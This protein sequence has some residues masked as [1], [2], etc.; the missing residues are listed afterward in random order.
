MSKLVTFFLVMLLGC[1]MLGAIMRGGGG[2]VAVALAD[3]VTATNTTLTVDSTTDFLST[4]YVIIQAEKILY[5]SRTAT[6]FMGCTRGYDGTV[7]AE[8][9]AGALVYT[10]DANAINNALGFN[11]A[12]TQD[13]WG[14]L[15]VLAIP[16]N[17]FIRTIPRI[18]RINISF[19]AG[20]LAV[21]GWLWLVMAA[22]FVITLAL[23]IVGGMRVR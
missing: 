10:A 5:T 15:S 23:A 11:V 12:A 21:I 8:H 1:S 7:A 2:I 17:F 14:W 20:P 22:G 9:E 6:T 4:D 19:L 13:T 18:I 16:F 3:D